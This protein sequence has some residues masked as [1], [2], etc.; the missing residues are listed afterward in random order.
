MDRTQCRTTVLSCAVAI[1]LYAPSSSLAEPPSPVASQRVLETIDAARAATTEVLRQRE[2]RRSQQSQAKT[3]SQATGSNTTGSNTTG[4]SMPGTSQGTDQSQVQLGTRATPTPGQDD[5]RGDDVRATALPIPRHGFARTALGTLNLTGVGEG[6]AM[7]PGTAYGQV[8]VP[9][10]RAAL[11][12]GSA[13]AAPRQG[14][15]TDTRRTP[16]AASYATQGPRAPSA[17]RRQIPARLRQVTRFATDVSKT[18]EEG[19]AG[20]YLRNRNLAAASTFPARLASLQANNTW[21]AAPFMPIQAKDLSCHYGVPSYRTPQDFDQDETPVHISADDMSGNLEREVTYQGDV[22]MVQGDRATSSDIARY[23]RDEGYVISSGDVVYSAP[24]VTLTSDQPVKSDLRTNETTILGGLYQFN[25]SIARG[26][27]G[28]LVRYGN[29]NRTH[30]DKA[31]FSGCPADHESWHFTATDIDI[32]RGEDFGDAR[33]VTLWLGSVPVFYTPYLNFPLSNRRKTGLLYPSVAYNSED[34]FVYVQPIYFNLAPNYD[35]TL[36]VASYGHR[37]FKFDNEFRYM[38]FAGTSGSINFDFM[39][40]DKKAD[41]NDDQGSQ[42][43][44]RFNWVHSTS[45]LDNDLKIK[46]DYARVRKTDYDYNSDFSGDLRVEDDHVKQ[47]LLVTYD[48]PTYNL[49]LEARA[50]Q[51]LLPE[52]VYNYRPFSMLPQFKGSTYHVWNHLLFTFDT[53]ITHFK[54]NHDA[55][56]MRGFDATRAHFEPT[57][58]YHIFDAHGTTLDARVKG[59]LT[60]YDQGDEKYLKGGAVKSVLG[61]DHLDPHVTRALYLLELRGKTTLERKVLDLRHTQT[62]EPEIQYQYIPYK[63]QDHIALYDTTDRVKD[64]YTNFSYQRFTGLDRIADTNTITFGLTTRLL[65]AHDR[66]KLRASVSQAYSFQTTRTKLR[67]NDSSN[68]NPRSPITASLD[69][70]PIEGLNLHGALSY[71]NETNRLDRYEAYATYTARNG[72]NGQISYR[73]HRDGNYSLESKV[74]DLRQLGLSA[75][76]P[77]GGNWK[78]AGAFYRDLE[79]KENIDIKAAIKY[80]E[81]CWSLSL[82]YENYTNIKW[83]KGWKRIRERSFGLQFELKGLAVLSPRGSNGF[84]QSSRLV[85]YFDPTSLNR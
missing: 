15:T 85:P 79:E 74:V 50:Y 68:T 4:S 65:D 1:A 49:S 61:Y 12:M 69:L 25:G 34:G 24:D 35:Y 56:H 23:N 43:R 81:C 46:L 40:H 30:V 6:S 14:T 48:R 2:E 16:P 72:F 76:V 70:S 19:G 10:D 5:G 51:S 38:P 64:Y 13:P 18:M 29:E 7:G 62:L 33:N 73:F 82:V 47:S 45:L 9:E 80:E 3:K 77:L 39:P 59:F 67:Y 84:S 21:Q 26:T 32:D 22:I 63:N 60:Y 83:S 41:I 58:K 31:T 20:Q 8:T 71:N 75:T 11:A 27:T 44:W 37:G 57:I 78:V 42:K 53:E 52:T 66:E 54:G 17:Q 28:K 36:K 55:T